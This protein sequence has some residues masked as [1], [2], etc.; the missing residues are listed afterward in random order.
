MSDHSM[1][2]KFFL[3]SC[4]LAA[5]LLIKAGAPIVPIA[6]GMAVAGLVTWKLQRRT[7]RLPR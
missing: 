6:A 7:T 5:G 1:K 3:G 4:I 2:W